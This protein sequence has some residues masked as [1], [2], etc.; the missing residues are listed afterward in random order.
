MMGPI[1]QE[2]RAAVYMAGGVLAEVI[3]TSLKN[4]PKFEGH[5]Q[6]WVLP[7]YGLGGVYGFEPMKRLL[8]DKK[9]LL[10]SD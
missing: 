3:F 9:Y 6:L 10:F 8:M 5:T 4:P 2:K 7:L 1:T